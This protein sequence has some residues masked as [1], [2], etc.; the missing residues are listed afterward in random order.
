MDNVGRFVWHCDD[1]CQ[2]ACVPV[3]CD[4]QAGAMTAREARSN[5]PVKRVVALMTI[6]AGT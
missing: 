6:L 5:A 1:S 2:P 3:M 4:T